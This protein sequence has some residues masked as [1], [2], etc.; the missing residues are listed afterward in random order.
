MQSYMHMRC[1][2]QQLDTAIQQL[3]I[4]RQLDRTRQTV[5]RPRQTSTDLDAHRHMQSGSTGSTATRQLLDRLDRQG[6]VSPSTVRLPTGVKPV[7]LDRYR[8]FMFRGTWSH[9]TGPI[10]IRIPIRPLR[11][12]ART[13]RSVGNERSSRRMSEGKSMSAIGVTPRLA[14]K[15]IHASP[16]LV[17]PFCVLSCRAAARDRDPLRRGLG[18]VY[19]DR[20]R[21]LHV[22]LCRPR[23]VTYSR[24][25]VET[26]KTVYRQTIA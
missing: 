18:F 20:D 6:L 17:V 12:T 21:S 2:A 3:D 4:A 24:R 9:P 14:F 25:Q 26:R 11:T 10:P 1:Q 7:F 15:P 5:D 8:H 16:G 23:A 19:G 22:P 13:G